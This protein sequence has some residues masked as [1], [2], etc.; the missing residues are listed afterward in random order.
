MASEAGTMR[1]IGEW[2]LAAFLLVIVGA[3]LH[4]YPG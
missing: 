2:M 1:E 3:W 4:F